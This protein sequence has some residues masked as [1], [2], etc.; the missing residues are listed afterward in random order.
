MQTVPQALEL[1]PDKGGDAERFRLLQ[2]NLGTLGLQEH[3]EILCAP[4][5]DA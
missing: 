4:G 5:G 2:E 1:H 3:V